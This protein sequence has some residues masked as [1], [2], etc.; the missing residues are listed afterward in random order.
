[1]S[2][3]HVLLS[4]SVFRKYLAMRHF[5][6]RTDSVAL[7]Y[8]KNPKNPYKSRIGQWGVELNEYK[9]DII[10]KSG[11]K[12]LL[13]DAMSRNPNPFEKP[14]DVDEAIDIPLF[15]VDKEE[16]LSCDDC[17]EDHYPPTDLQ[18][19]DIV[20]LQLLDD[21]IKE[22]YEHLD[23][24]DSFKVIDGIMCYVEKEGNDPRYRI[25]CPLTQ[26]LCHRDLSFIKI[27]CTPGPK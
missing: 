18:D 15:V 2:G 23:H 21:W 12:N 5:V 7:T 16:S 20:H 3:T 8:L 10:Y 19:I 9:C 17:Q 24:E 4:V 25:A 6:I 13:A 1:M 11:K 26:R 27:Q 22:L 14:L